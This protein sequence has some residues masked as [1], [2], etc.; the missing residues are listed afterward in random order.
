MERVRRAVQELN[1]LAE[2]SGGEVVRRRDGSHSLATPTL[3][4]TFWS[5][6]LQ[7]NEALLR[8]Y[9]AD[10]RF[11]S[12]GVA[13]LRTV[14]PAL[15]IMERRDMIEVIWLLWRQESSAAG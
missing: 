15:C 8:K 5:D 14:S 6:G 9:A 3:H 11:S 7:L 13:W 10:S 12:E 4:L 1:A 2:G